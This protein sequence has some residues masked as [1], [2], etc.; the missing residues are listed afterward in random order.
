MESDAPERTEKRPPAVYAEDRPPV[1]CPLLD[2]SEGL[3]I[4]PDRPAA[5]LPTRDAERSRRGV[6]I[7][8]PEGQGLT[9]SKPRAPENW[10]FSSLRG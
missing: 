2:E 5:R 9:H 4:E 3:G 1:G 8:G 10:G 7:G 6:E